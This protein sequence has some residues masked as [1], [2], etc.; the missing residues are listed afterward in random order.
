MN[1]TDFS[2]KRF[3]RCCFAA[4]LAGA[5]APA[6]AQDFKIATLLPD[7]TLWMQ[8]MRKGA[9]EIQKRTEGRVVFKFYPG[10]SMGSDRVVLRKVRAGQL[11]G[12]MLTGGSLAEIHSDT[13]IYS[14]PFLFRSY[15]E[16]DYVR[17]RMDKT[18]AQSLL[19]R[20]FVTFGFS[21][22]G[23]AYIM[24]N[25][26]L[27]RVDDL[28]SEKVW[29][30]EGDD[31]SRALF[32][33][34]GVSPI[35]LPLTDMLTGLQTGLITTV[36]SSAIGA[37]ALQWHTKVRYITDV[38]TLYL[39][40]LLAIDKRAYSRMSSADQNVV[41]DVMERIYLDLN[42]QNRLDDQAA[43]QALRKQ[44]IKFVDMAPE[45]IAKLRTAADQTL[46]QLGKKGMFSLALLR[47]AR[48]HLET[49]RR[50]NPAAQR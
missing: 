28:K 4:L 38:P 5:A 14:L 30:P 49:F 34:L 41:R 10:G 50:Q 43:H 11:H 31:L 12:G 20:G 44:G 17:S 2:F 9:E 40:G 23:F 18:V 37:I 33:N 32:E 15:E 1:H 24:S 8:E 26:P 21:H 16:V 39:Y 3:Y 29:I 7:G 13:Q 25:T 46:E 19:D 42:R 48:G 27:K 35:P 22:G 45:E 6:L 47:T 36:A